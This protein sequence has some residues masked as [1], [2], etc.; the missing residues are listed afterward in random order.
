M[1]KVDGDMYEGI[2]KVSL[3]FTSY[4]YTISTVSSSFCA[5]KSA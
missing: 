4:I 3:E 1:C 2:V 5:T